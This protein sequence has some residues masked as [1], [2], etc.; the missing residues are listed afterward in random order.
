[1]NA[2]NSPLVSVV[3]PSYNSNDY[4]LTT[5]DSAIGQSYRPLEIIFVD[6]GSTDNSLKTV[7]NYLVNMSTKSQSLSYKIFSQKNQGPSVARNKG[8]KEACG[9]YVAFL[10]A[11]DKWDQDKIRK[12]VE[13]LEN[14]LIIGLVATLT[15]PLIKETEYSVISFPELLIRSRFSTTSVLCRKDIVEKFY[16]NENQRY[17]EDYLLWLQIAERYT[18]LIINEY[19]TFQNPKPRFGA[20]GLSS[21]L[22]LMEKGELSNYLFFYRK[23]SIS[24]RYLL[25]I[26]LFSMLRYIRRCI[27]T[28]CK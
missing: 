8:I 16:F 21:K 20:K 4:I 17:S 26:S 2:M 13:F 6:D 5:L 7:R 9:K 14:N 1:M 25:R 18:C 19:L 15:R 11:D 22:W 12:Q 24:L 28:Y 27:L 23:K 3:I 10:D